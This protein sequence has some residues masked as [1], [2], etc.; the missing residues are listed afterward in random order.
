MGDGKVALILD[1][2]G[3]AQNANLREGGKE[4]ADSQEL[5]VSS[6]SVHDLKTLLL[7]KVGEQGRVAIPVSHIARLEE[8]P[9]TIK[10]TAGGQEVV[11]YRGTILPVL[12]FEYVV[13]DLWLCVGRTYG[14]VSNGGCEI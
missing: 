13:G 14:D 10:E 5:L 9:E 7:V 1:V 12:S 4:Q 8:M 2:P 6:G 3:L 11:Q